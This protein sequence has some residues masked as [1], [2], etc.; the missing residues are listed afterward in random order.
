MTERDVLYGVST[1]Y[2]PLLFKGLYKSRKE[3]KISVKVVTF[4]KVTS[5]KQEMFGNKFKFSLP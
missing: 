5:S 3:H 1:P 2:K 4:L